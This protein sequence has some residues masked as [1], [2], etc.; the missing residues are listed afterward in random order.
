M[1]LNPMVSGLL[2]GFLVEYMV[3]IEL[4]VY[5][6]LR[7]G[8]RNTQKRENGR[9]TI[10]PSFKDSFVIKVGNGNNTLFWRDPW[11]STGLRPMGYFPKLAMLNLAKLE[12]LAL[13]ISGQNYLSWVLDGE[14]YLAANGLGDTIQAE[15]ETTVETKGQG[16]DIL[17]TFF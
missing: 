1:Q 10:D 17:T 12:F 6:H 14:I 4:M 11:C 15:E 7:I 5:G 13:D 9:V 16:L 3:V 8:R 2:G